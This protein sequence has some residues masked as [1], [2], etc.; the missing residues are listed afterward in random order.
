VK[1]SVRNLSAETDGVP[2][3]IAQPD[4]NEVGPGLLIVHHHY[5][6]TGHLKAVACDFA[7]LGYTAVVPDL[8]K[9]LGFS[10]GL[11][12]AQ[13][14]TTD[15]QFVEIINDGW[16]YLT[17]R[18]NVDGKRCAVVGFCMG[19]RIAIHFIAATPA[20]RGFVGYY[21]SVRDEGSSELRPRHPNEAVRDFKCPSLIFFGGKDHVASV[22]VQERLWKSFRENGQHLEWHFFPH[23]AHGFA[24]GDGDGYDPR[25][26]ELAWPLV[27]D[28]L[29]RELDND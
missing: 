21:P 25:L 4:C 18:K 14:K 23:A 29:A 8:Y 12:E 2:G 27:A 13:K 19:G 3:Y 1:I 24:L 10:D 5:G 28:F 11:H 15:G 6:I 9:L 26:A 16:R 17:E 7:K 20:V 22:S